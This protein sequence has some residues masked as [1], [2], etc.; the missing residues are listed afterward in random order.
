MELIRDTLF[1]L[2]V[3]IWACTECPPRG[4]VRPVLRDHGYQIDG[5]DVAMRLSP[6]V[7]GGIGNRVDCGIA[8]EPDVVIWN[9]FRRTRV[10]VECKAQSFS[11]ASSNSRQCRALLLAAGNN[12]ARPFTPEASETFASYLMPEVYRDLQEA[13]LQSLTDELEPLVFPYHC[14]ASFVFGLR[15]SEEGNVFLH[16]SQE[17]SPFNDYPEGGLP[18]FAVGPDEAPVPLFQVALCPDAM[19]GSVLSSTYSTLV[20]FYRLV[21]ELLVAIK[22]QDGAQ[23]L[24][25]PSDEILRGLLNRLDGFWAGPK[26]KSMLDFTHA[27]I[28][29]VLR[30]V[31]TKKSISSGSFP[32]AHHVTLDG[33]R[34]STIRN[35]L[36]NL[37]ESEWSDA[38]ALLKGGG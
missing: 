36:M 31:S 28:Y 3:L 1:Q 32:R 20:F 16:I 18:V 22:E 15:S 33:V 26:R 34:V 7:I 8:P 9:P 4:L 6:E 38:I 21:A 19:N 2:N 23:V 37:S 13:T 30:E 11:P 17:D 5:F 27:A 35:K 25:F 12:T 29:K 14:G 10:L 24:V